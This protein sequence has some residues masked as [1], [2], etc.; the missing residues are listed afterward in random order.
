MGFMLLTL[1][2][3]VHPQVH[4]NDCFSRILIVLNN[5]ERDD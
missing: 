1:L 4:D 3:G 2:W 5:K